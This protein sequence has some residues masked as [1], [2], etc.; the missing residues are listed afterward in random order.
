[1]LAPDALDIDEQVAE[2]SG[3]VEIRELADRRK[4]L[5]RR[6]DALYETM[7]LMAA[8]FVLAT[9]STS[10]DVGRVLNSMG[11]SVTPPPMPV[12]D[13]DA[14][15]KVV[16]SMFGLM[17]LVNAAY[18]L[19]N[20]LIGFGPWILPGGS[21]AIRPQVIRYALLFTI[22]Y[23]AVMIV[24]IKL[25]RKWH[26]D[27]EFDSRRPE[28]LMVAL[29]VYAVSLICFSVPLSWYIRH[30]WSM[31]PLLFSANQG[32][33]GYFTG[34]YVD[35]AIKRQGISPTAAAWHGFLQLCVTAIAMT[36]YPPPYLEA[37]QD[38]LRFSYVI[39]FTAAQSGVSGF[40]IGLL[41]QLFYVR[42]ASG[43]GRSGAGAPAR[44][45]APAGAPLAA[46]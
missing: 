3:R 36:A 39:V 6:C 27:E 28:N 31:A 35:R 15:A 45:S 24:A 20:W 23:A 12:L 13:W 42:E 37:V 25:K 17:L 30:A 11:F 29:I 22:A 26:Q 44:A 33:L 2:H 4:A 16:A 43:P 41:F 38:P 32:V 40:L 14:V 7:C 18:A 19:F 10:E 9:E 21:E 34:L 8:L 1:V 46:T 5:Q